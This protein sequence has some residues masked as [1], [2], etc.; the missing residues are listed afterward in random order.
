MAVDNRTGI[1]IQVTAKDETARVLKGVESG[2]IRFVGAVSAALATVKVVLFPI[3]EAREF[4]EQLLNVGK[5]TEYTSAQLR[6]LGSE[7]KAISQR[8]N[9]SEVD[10][11]KVAAAGGQLGI[12]GEE[13]VKGLV[14]FTEAAARFSSVLDVSVED[15]AN[16]IG[17]LSNIFSVAIS[18]A[19]RI[20][21]LLNEVS[22]RSTASGEDL[23]DIMQR[24]GT[25]Q[26]TL[27]IQQAAALA[28]T[29]RDL[30]LTL[31]TVGTS[32]NKIFLDLNTKSKQVAT[33]VGLPVEAFSNILQTDGIKA[34][35][36]YIDALRE[37]PATQRSALSEQITGGGRIAALVTSLI[38]DANAGYKL[39]NSNLSAAKDGFEGGT[40]AMNEQQRVLQGLNAQLDILI[41][42]FKATAETV[43]RGALPFLRELTIEMQELLRSEET[44]RV[45][46]EFGEAIGN[47]VVGIVRLIS[48][49]GE[50]EVALTA[51]VR[52]VQLFI[53]L[54]LTQAIFNGGAAFVRYVQNVTAA[55]RAM[56]GLVL[57]NRQVV[58]SIA[59]QAEAVA[60]SGTKQLSLAARAGVVLNGLYSG[61]FGLQ[62]QLNDGINTQ[63]SAEEAIAGVRQRR[64]A[65]LAQEAA[66]QRRLT[67]LVKKGGAAA[68]ANAIAGG[69]SAAQARQAA[70]QSIARNRELLIL[71]KQ[72]EA[73][74]RLEANAEIR[75]QQAIVRTARLQTDSAAAALRDTTRLGVVAGAARA[76]IEGLVGVLAKGFGLFVRGLGVAG[77]V[78][79]L[80]DLLGLLEPLIAGFK[81]FFG[82]SEEAEI[83]AQ[84]AAR[85]QIQRFEEQKKAADELAE[86]Y[87]KLVDAW[88]RSPKKGEGALEKS[89]AD[90]FTQLEVVQGK[91][92]SLS[93]SDAT[94]ESNIRNLQNELFQVRTLLDEANDKMQELVSGRASAESSGA[95]S[96]FSDLFSGIAK[97]TLT[98]YNAEI[99]KQQQLIVQLQNRVKDLTNSQNVY[100]GAQLRNAQEIKL[101]H[102]LEEE[103]IEQLTNK[104]SEEG[105]KLTQLIQANTAAL[106]AQTKARQKLSELENSGRDRNKGLDTEEYANARNQFEL[107]TAKVEETKE[108]LRTAQSEAGIAATTFADIAIPPSL[109]S[110]LDAVNQRLSLLNVISGQSINTLKEQVATAT[111]AVQQAN[112][113][114]VAV[115]QRTQQEIERIRR[116]SAVRI[117]SVKG[118]GGVSVNEEILEEE[119]RR[120]DRLIEQVEQRARAETAA[121][122]KRRAE[123]LQL[124]SAL[125]REI[126]LN[127]KLGQSKER[128][129][130]ISGEQEVAAR[131]R[132]VQLAGESVAFEKLRKA[133]DTIAKQARTTADAMASAYDKAKKELE[134]SIGQQLVDIAEQQERIINRANILSRAKLETNLDKDETRRKSEQ[135]RLLDLA[136][137]R[138]EAEG[139]TADEIERVISN[140]EEQNK[141]ED[142]SAARS[143][144][145][146]LL[147]KD[148]DNQLKLIAMN[149]ETVNK[150]IKESNDL[151]AQSE[152]AKIGG[153]VEL[154]GKLAEQSV[155]SMDKASQALDKLNGNIDKYK[156]LA[157]TPVN[158]SAGNPRF[159]ITDDQITE[160]ENQFGKLAKT[161]KENNAKV[162]EVAKNMT[163]EGAQAQEGAL[164]QI[165]DRINDISKEL[166][167][168]SSTVPG[169]AE[170]LGAVGTA[171]E[172]AAN[173]SGQLD[174]NLQSIANASLANIREM[175]ALKRNEAAANNIAKAMEKTASAIVD[176]KLLDLA[177]AD[178]TQGLGKA[179]SIPQE[180]LD[181]NTADL[182]AKLG[183]T[184]FNAN[185]QFPSARQGLQD[186]LSSAPFTAN[187]N[188]Q[189][190]TGIAL[191]G[192]PVQNNADGGYIQ[193]PGT[194]TSD[195]I[196]SWLSNG[197]Y[198]M[199]AMTTRTFG[200]GFF[201]FL[202]KA[203]RG[204]S[205]VLNG[206]LSR[207]HFGLP[208]FAGGGFVSAGNL[209]G[210]GAG[211]MQPITLNLG[212]ESFT[213]YTD[214]Q[215]GTDLARVA[216]RETLKKGKRAG[217][218]R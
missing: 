198:V 157:S 75:K 194:G 28:A 50:N 43:G 39:L 216:R 73:A 67:D 115:E 35:Q 68:Q 186:Q 53:G 159:L 98:D 12:G 38:N 123:G 160:V 215:T 183:S 208:A 201:S 79:A 191:G 103:A 17:K 190:T 84:E 4:E 151:S 21:S 10:L 207:G 80:L 177:K 205:R 88:R 110:N 108:A 122:V 24:I 6:E 164:K 46:T 134:D 100:R 119:R 82:I 92:R 102:Q 135:Q 142:E 130:K 71:S 69:R 188:L 15:A 41:N 11:A 163:E 8:L 193:G 59:Q 48:V 149:Q 158:D 203:A 36:L 62:D 90:L 167:S 155:V 152:K 181:K 116:E 195:S 217:V 30:G 176:G 137:S 99:E 60:T 7:L 218:R 27:N 156:D 58:T 124:V 51:L 16:G 189:P 31:E 118:V 42:T 145:T 74:I 199:D 14:A 204:G 63:R 23:L 153:N 37:L 52:L 22:N 171:V 56:T 206:L 184:D 166:S 55:T 45:F 127:S 187:V 114:I 13:G 25:A 196:L 162:T 54:K 111:Q 66:E 197:E 104:W 81:K 101:A 139:A 85:S 138:L 65:L 72:R 202:Q 117:A 106:D 211:M 44:V 179:L 126:D 95:R 94:A 170:N 89:M 86:R 20:S 161:I 47:V 148:I 32:F 18:D 34:L 209:A 77:L 49:I 5:T 178:F 154:A 132:L 70:A 93:V 83:A 91:I 26:G 147:K 113:Q 109:R 143:R 3:N 29:G 105:Y 168:L 33:L 129:V 165:T 96:L 214:Q 173:S 2:V 200:A 169:L 112:N 131:R 210:V 76:G 175:D 146:L 141:R 182:Q 61:L 121:A 120:R 172:K 144:E 9:I 78:I 180:V 1:E 97:R 57:G 213:T 40:S 19:E 128:L 174:K 212:G 185:I 133:Q 87:D 192:A 150:L 125:N 140:M 107:L 64:N 136:R